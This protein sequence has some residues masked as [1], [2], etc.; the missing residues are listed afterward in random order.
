MFNDVD[1]TLKQFFTAE[2]P[3]AGGEMDVSFERPTREWSGRLSRPTL[4]LF[5][6]DIRERTGFRDDTPEMKYEAGGRFRR[7]RPP[8]RIDLSYMVTA[9]AREA[10]DE[11]RILSRTLAAMF[12]A[13]EI[14]PRFFQGELVNSDYP[15]LARIVPSDHVAKPADMWGVL[16]NELRTSLVWVV[17]APLDAFTPSEGPLVRTRELRV[18][19]A[20]QDWRETF[21]QIAGTARKKGSPNE[22]LPGVRVSVEGTALRAVTGPDG[23]FSFPGIA[24]GEHVIRYE[25]EDG[26][27]GSQAISVPGADYDIEL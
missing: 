1:D 24:P 6:Y 12:R 27:T 8:R 20:S 5:L 15:L 13:G 17:T 3:I 25:S 26:S 18:G 22:A 10:D 16:D 21:V 11:H 4:N 14:D 9:W 7:Q 19:D 23:R 2:I